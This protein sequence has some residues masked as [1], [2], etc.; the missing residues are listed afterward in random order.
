VL[1]R[2]AVEGR[3]FKWSSVA[4]L[5]PDSE[6]SG[7]GQHLMALMRRQLIQPDPSAFAGED[8]FRFS[9]VLIQE[10]AYA[11]LPK[12][13]CSELHERLANRLALTQDG[14]DEI[15]G[16]HLEQ[17]FRCREQLGL[18]DDR[19]R[20]L[21][22][23]AKNRLEAA[24]RKALLRGDPA[25]A[26][27][28]L[29][30]AVLLLT[31]DDPARLDLLP[32]LGVALFEAGQ[33][34]DADRVLTE[35]I[36]H[37]P[38]ELLQARAHVEQQ[39]VRLQAEPGAIDEAHEVAARTLSVFQQ[40]SDDSGQ[41]RAWSLRASVAWIVGRAG[42]ADEAWRRAAEHAR[43]A[44][45]T[46]E[47]FEILAWR[48]SAA[49]LG[50]TPVDEAIQLCLDIRSQ[51]RSSPVAVAETLHPLGV[52]HAMNGDFDTARSLIR[53]GNAIIEELGRIYSAAISH[54]E[55]FVEMLAG[56]PEVAEER[57][58]RAYEMLEQM[59]GKDLLAY[60]SALLAQVIYLQ[61]RLEEA[62]HFCRVTREAAADEDV[63]AQV[64]GIG[65]YAKILARQGRRE[66]A[67]TLARGAGELAARTDFLVHHGDAWLDL[68][69]V[70]QLNEE[71]QEAVNALRAGLKLY[72]QK[73]NLV[74][75]K[76]A[77]MRLEGAR[78]E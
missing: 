27:T 55:A 11:G 30:R 53:E 73:G 60:T 57:L 2:A 59:G 21:A 48:A 34:S 52:L 13:L 5:L 1:E 62:A 74:S 6:R 4:T 19:E 61:N 77:R 76:R 10:A 40:R 63:L 50:P 43:R 58:R 56:R 51:V 25:A 67:E 68:A 42:S 64:V 66:E 46:R 12:E 9:H 7:L 36:E 45:E 54:H 15:V 16:Y 20:G 29:E 31:P 32:S 28:L 39:F 47:L 14:E 44:D 22:R 78:S 33:L 35:A 69:E 23:E 71:P 65:A 49:V 70:L 3:N 37:A 17:A 26:G 18:V 41:S 75:A 38:D 72:E 8:A 24:A